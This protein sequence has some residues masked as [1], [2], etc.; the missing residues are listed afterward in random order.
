MSS[1]CN[2]GKNQIG[3]HQNEV[4]FFRTEFIVLGTEGAINIYRDLAEKLELARFCKVL[5]ENYDYCSHARTREI[6]ESKS[7]AKT[8][9]LY[10]NTKTY[11][12]L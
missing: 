3:K 1:R 6:G 5:L 10:Y 11:E 7:L 12:V 8:C 4:Y 9:W 2:R